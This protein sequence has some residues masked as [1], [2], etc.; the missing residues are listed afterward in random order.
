MNR[1]QLSILAPTFRFNPTARQNLATLAAIGG[2]DIEVLIG[3]NSTNIDKWAYLE[4]IKDLSPNVQVFRH[5]TDLGAHGNFQFLLKH[6]TGDFCCMAADDDIFTGDYFRAGLD[7]AKR[8]SDTAAAS[9]VFMSLTK[10]ADD[11]ASY[12]FRSTARLEAT[13]L[14]RIKAYHGGINFIPYCVMRRDSFVAMWRY[15][16]ENPLR[17]S[18]L[19]QIWAYSTLSE[20]TYR[21]DHNNPIYLYI[22]ENWATPAA[23][24]ANDAKFYIALGLPERFTNF[25]WL[26]WSFAALHYFHSHYRPTSLRAEEATAIADHLFSHYMAVFK[27]YYESTPQ[28]Y[29]L[30]LADAPEAM[31]ALLALVAETEH[32]ISSLFERFLTIM[33]AFSPE[34]TVQYATFLKNSLLPDTK[35]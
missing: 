25:H 3:D 13:G 7:V 14:E 33:N 32:A 30:L 4:K 35:R 15:I 18:Y 19:D 6:A 17:A 31:Q 9:G 28:G 23:C 8:N 10:A 12:S 2:D 27:W 16:E 20:G 11:S 24:W 5:K 1:I 29:A 26:S 21:L 34:L 22:N